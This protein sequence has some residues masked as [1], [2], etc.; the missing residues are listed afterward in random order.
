MARSTHLPPGHRAIQSYYATLKTFSG[1]HVEHEGALETAFSHLLAETAKPHGWT[2][3]PKLPPMTLTYAG[4]ILSRQRRRSCP[5][6]R[7]S[8]EIRRLGMARSPQQI[9]GR[10]AG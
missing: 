6:C 7:S 3:I 10:P 4:Q 2:L 1:Q 8:G 5:T 9:L